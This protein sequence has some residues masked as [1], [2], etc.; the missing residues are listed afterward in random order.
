MMKRERGNQK[1][2]AAQ[3]SAVSKDA[4]ERVREKREKTGNHGRSTKR[5]KEEVHKRK[6]KRREDKNNKKAKL[7]IGQ[8]EK[9][10]DNITW[11]MSR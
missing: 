9:K 7:L 10:Y 1:W 6:K 4:K 2:S 5:N 11:K 8:R 3:R